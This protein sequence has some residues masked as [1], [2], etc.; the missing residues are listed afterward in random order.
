MKQL[1]TRHSI[2]G[3]CYSPVKIHVNEIMGRK[4]K[5]NFHLHIDPSICLLLRL[6][7]LW[8]VICRG[9]RSNIN[10]VF[11]LCLEVTVFVHI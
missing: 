6:P 10:R 11:T 1:N 7:C 4:S 3:W 5:Q 9:F 2:A 8:Q